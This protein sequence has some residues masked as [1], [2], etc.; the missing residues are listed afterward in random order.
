MSG[1][2]SSKQL[3]RVA[4]AFPR[5][6]ITS[7][8]RLPLMLRQRCVREQAEQLGERNRTWT[9]RLNLALEARQSSVLKPLST[10]V[11]LDQ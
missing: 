2:G 7:D 3:T 11:W 4:P 10:V 9:G 8:R 1:K 6:Q 5:R